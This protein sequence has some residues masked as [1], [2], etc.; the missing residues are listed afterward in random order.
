M[1]TRVAEGGS[2]WREH[3]ITRERVIA[4]NGPHVEPA[5][6]DVWAHAM[7]ELDRFDEG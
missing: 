2:T 5:L 6:P 4:R 3:G 1:P 7:V